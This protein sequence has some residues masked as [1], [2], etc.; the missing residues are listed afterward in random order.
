[1][2]PI[3]LLILN[4]IP[5]VGFL[6][7]LFIP[8]NNEWLL[9][10]FSFLVVGAHMICAQIFILA[11]LFSGLHDIHYMG[12]VFYESDNY[13]FFLSLYFDHVSATYVFVGSLLTFLITVYSRYYLHREKGYKRFFTTI[14]MFYFGFNLIIC[15]GNFEILFTGWEILGIS[16]F[17]LIAFYRDRY[18]PVKNALKVFSIYRLGDV[19][20]LLAMWLSH[21]LWHENI[22]FEQL[23]NNM[24]VHEHL[25][26]NTLFGFMLAILILLS[27]SAKSAQFPFSSWLPRAM[28]GPTPSSAIFYGSLSV[29]IGVFVLLRTSPL[30]ENQIW[31][32]VCI[33]LVGASTAFITNACARVQSSVKSQVAYSSLTQIG[34]MFVEVALGLYDLTLFHFA[35]NAFLRT[36]QLLVSPSVVSYLIR[37]QFYNFKPRVEAKEG[38]LVQ[39]VNMTIYLLSLKEWNMDFL[40]EAILWRPIKALGQRLSFLTNPV[41]FAIFILVS[42]GIYSAILFNEK[43]SF[44]LSTVISPVLAFLGLILVIKAFTERK[45]AMT[46]W[47]LV[48]GNHAFVAA[49][50]SV[51]DRVNFEHLAIYLS[52]VFIC[53]GLG[54]FALRHLKTLEKDVSLNGFLGHVYVHG[55]LGTIFL[56]ACLGI[57]GFPITSTFIGEDLIFHH[58]T[59]NHMWMAVF[60]SFSYVLDGLAIMRIYARVFLGPHA[61]DHEVASRSA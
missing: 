39:R 45:S 30:W 54:F 2:M 25:A 48:I 56:V 57:S 36:Y 8:R 41:G 5:L 32:R 44:E 23:N 60:V 40:L 58:I 50:V 18:L 12:P 51:L 55:T 33:A 53:G 37:E 47:M 52:G 49:A 11:W 24:L 34:I 7:C 29:H 27:A 6:L 46:A 16:S 19:G 20:L 38:G 17:L 35:G 42:L 10:R 26:T 13:K 3:F 22:S 15:S 61:G 59:S 14:M 1:M 31:A 43:A 28:E 4:S 21:I 9:S